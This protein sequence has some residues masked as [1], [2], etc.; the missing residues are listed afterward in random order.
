MLSTQCTGTRVKLQGLIDVW[1]K[2]QLISKCSFGAF[3]SS[4]K[5]TK[6]FIWNPRKN[7]VGFLE[8]L[9]TPKEYF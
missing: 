7:F 9:K 6:F 5:T 8:D 3:K 4:K 2:G 1:A